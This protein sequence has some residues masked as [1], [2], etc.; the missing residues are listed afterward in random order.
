MWTKKFTLSQN[1]SIVKKKVFPKMCRWLETPK[2]GDQRVVDFRILKRGCNCNV[3]DGTIDSKKNRGFPLP[4][5]FFLF[6][7]ATES[8]TFYVDMYG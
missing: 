2:K 3:N 8:S 6:L 1:F 4:T 5:F 7:S